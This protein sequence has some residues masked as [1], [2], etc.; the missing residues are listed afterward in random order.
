MDEMSAALGAY[1]SSGSWT[2]FTARR[3]ELTGRS[4]RCSAGESPAPVVRTDSRVV[5]ANRGWHLYQVLIDFE[6]AG[7]PRAEV[8][9]ADAR[10]RASP[11]RSTTFPSTASPSSRPAYD[12][13]RLPGAEA[14]YARVLALPLFPAM[15]DEDLS[16]VAGA[17]KAAL[18]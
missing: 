8:D 10:R 3:A 17:L 16:R 14:F 4:V 5:R 7:V 18:T 2:R 6:A 11:P 13:M 12:E 1:R 9:A 15:A